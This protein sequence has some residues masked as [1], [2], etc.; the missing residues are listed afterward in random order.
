MLLPQRPAIA[1]TLFAL[2][3]ALQAEAGREIYFEHLLL[4]AFWRCQAY[5]P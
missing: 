4:L 5:C 1:T 2:C 3:P